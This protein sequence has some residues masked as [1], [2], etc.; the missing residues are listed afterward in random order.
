MIG[1]KWIDFIRQTV[2]RIALCFIVTNQL[3]INSYPILDKS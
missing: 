1:L 2:H 3:K